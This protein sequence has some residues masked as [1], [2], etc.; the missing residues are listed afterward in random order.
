MGRV[1]HPR[2]F[3][4]LPLARSA[5]LAVTPCLTLALL[6]L[7]VSTLATYHPGHPRLH[8]SYVGRRLAQRRHGA[9]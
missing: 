1:S 9:P 3:M 5:V 2:P 7:T 4:V 6:V 8:L